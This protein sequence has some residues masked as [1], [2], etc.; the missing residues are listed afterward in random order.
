[1]TRTDREILFTA[2]GFLAVVLR[3]DV[4]HDKQAMRAMAVADLIESFCRSALPE[5]FAEEDLDKA[6]GA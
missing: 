6:A 1:M 4:P 5:S 3:D 2:L